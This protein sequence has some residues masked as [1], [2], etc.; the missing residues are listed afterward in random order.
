MTAAEIRLACLQLAASLVPQSS[1]DQPLLM[2]ALDFERFVTDDRSA[3]TIQDEIREKRL[4]AEQGY[5]TLRDAMAS[6]M[7]RL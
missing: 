7:P 1:G 3:V 4:R 2:A 6:G 5:R